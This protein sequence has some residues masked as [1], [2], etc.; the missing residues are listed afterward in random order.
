M[1]ELEDFIKQCAVTVTGTSL[2][3]NYT[4]PPIN[5]FK[6]PLILSKRLAGQVRNRESLKKS[7]F[8]VEF[9]LSLVDLNLVAEIFSSGRFD[10]LKS[11][12]G[13]L[14][15]LRELAKEI[16]IPRAG[17][18]SKVMI[19]NILLELC[20]VLISGQ[21][22]CHRYVH[23]LGETG[24]WTD[25]WCIHSIKYGSKMMVL[26]ESV[27]DPCDLF[28]SL[29][30][31]PQLQVL[32]DAC[33][34]INHLCVSEPDFASEMFGSNRG[35]FETPH[36]TQKPSRNHDCPDILPLSV[37]PRKVDENLLNLTDNKVHPVTG[38]VTRLVLGTKLSNSHKTNNECLFHDINNCKQAS[39]VKT[40][41]QEGLQVRRKYRRVTAGKRQS[42][43]SHFCFN[44]ALDIL[45]NLRTR[46]QQEL[47]LQKSGDFVVNKNTLV[48]E[49]V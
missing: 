31:P 20:N 14:S 49:F 6:L 47:A 5:V 43:E 34:F 45:E 12:E 42:L 38:K 33:T 11:K 39:S 17:K 19:Q 41:S 23:S 32:D 30:N 1:Y 28:L 25:D 18:L 9:D 26:K 4:K 37:N 46:R 13:N 10:L 15:E 29:K 7:N 24:G 44:F 36:K 2:F 27:I 8:L 16:K 22:N 48:A 40:M 35:C 21:G 3:Q